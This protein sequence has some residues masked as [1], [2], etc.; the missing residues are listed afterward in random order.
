[1]VV[2]YHGGEKEFLNK[3]I[4]TIAGEKVLVPIFIMLALA[5]KI[6]YQAYTVACQKKT[7]SPWEC[8]NSRN[9]ILLF[10]EPKH[11]KENDLLSGSQ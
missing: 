5:Q 9:G 7:M 4:T 11:L 1:L 10:R 8:R 3:P 6:N 2:L